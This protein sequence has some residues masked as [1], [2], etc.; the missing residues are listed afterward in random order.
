MKIHKCLIPLDFVDPGNM[1]EDSR[2]RNGAHINNRVRW[3]NGSSELFYSIR[4]I[5]PNVNIARLILATETQ[6]G[7]SIQFSKNVNNET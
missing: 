1:S 6:H 5:Q 3:K 4:N 2:L 7:T